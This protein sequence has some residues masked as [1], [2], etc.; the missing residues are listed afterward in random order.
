MCPVTFGEALWQEA[1][2]VRAAT[3]PGVVCPA[4]KS[5]LLLSLWPVLGDPQGLNFPELFYLQ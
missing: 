3:T 2:G 4:S 1:F 5:T